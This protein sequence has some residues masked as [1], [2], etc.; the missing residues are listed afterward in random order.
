[1]SGVFLAI[2]CSCWF[3]NLQGGSLTGT[4]VASP[5]TLS[6]TACKAQ[7]NTAIVEEWTFDSWSSKTRPQSGGFSSNSPH[8]EP[9]RARLSN[10]TSCSY[11]GLALQKVP[12]SAADFEGTLCEM[13]TTLEQGVAEQGAE[14]TWTISQQAQAGRRRSRKSR[15]RADR[16]CRK[17]S[18]GGNNTQLQGESSHDTTCNWSSGEFTGGRSWGASA[19]TCS[20]STST[21]R[22]HDED[23]RASTWIAANDGHASP[24]V[25]TEAS[26][27]G[28]EAQFDRDKAQSWPP[29][30]DGQDTAPDY[31]FVGKDYQAGP[32]L[33]GLCGT[34]RGAIPKTQGVVP[35]H[36]CRACQVP[37]AKDPG[38]RADQSRDFKGLPNPIEY[39]GGSGL[40]SGRDGRCSSSSFSTGGGHASGFARRV[41]G[42]G[43]RHGSSHYTSS[44]G[45]GFF[46]EIGCNFAYQSCQGAPQGEGAKQEGSEDWI[47]S[48]L[49]D[50]LH[51]TQHVPV[52]CVVEHVFAGAWS[53]TQANVELHY[54]KDNLD[55]RSGA[56][57]VNSQQGGDGTP[58]R[59][60][61]FNPQVEFIYL[62]GD[63]GSSLFSV[64]EVLPPGELFHQV[65]YSS[66]DEALD[67]EAVIHADSDSVSMMDGDFV[68]EDEDDAYVILHNFG[69]LLASTQ[70]TIIS[71]LE[72]L[73]VITY[74]VR[75]HSLGR[76]DTWVTTATLPH[77]RQAV[78]NLWE[79]AIPQFAACF[80]FAVT[81]QP[82]REL[83]VT[84][85]WILVVEIDPGAS[86]P[87]HHCPILSMT[88]SRATGLIGNPHP[89]LVPKN[90][91]S[92]QLVP[93][94]L[95]SQYCLP[96][97]MRTCHLEIAGEVKSPYEDFVV[98]PGSLSKLLFGEPPPGVCRARQWFPDI[99]EVALD[100][101]A[102]SGQGL[103][104][105]Q[106]VL[107]AADIPTR[108]IDVDG[109]VATDP[110]ALRRRLPP[111]VRKGR[112]CWVPLG[113]LHPSI[114][115]RPGQLH[116]VVGS[117]LRGPSRP[118]LIFICR[119]TAAYQEFWSNAV[120]WIDY[121]TT[122][123]ELIVQLFPDEDPLFR[124]NVV[125]SSNH[126]VL[127]TL[128]QH[129]SGSVIIAYVGRSMSSGG[130]IETA[131]AESIN[132][133][134]RS[135]SLRAVR[136]DAGDSNE[137][138][139]V[140]QLHRTLH[141]NVAAAGSSFQRRSKFLLAQGGRKHVLVSWAT[142][143]V[144]LWEHSRR[145]CSTL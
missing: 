94:H 57:M 25:G 85:A 82:L 71:D 14:G 80:A 119:S 84:K 107:H 2:V 135:M 144:A 114:G 123:E 53:W 103:T 112:L 6:E 129:H 49:V 118:L 12:D 72:P 98:R 145:R 127:G 77:L 110:D 15:G 141:Q 109:T 116:F 89:R 130:L 22:G 117:P 31:S 30:Q 133:M 26:R 120:H 131:G 59:R 21:S 134:Q 24:R 44:C 10:R 9:P 8:V 42:Y 37:H 51:F 20:S 23:P 35:S 19:R 104:H 46:Q 41:R 95:Y 142:P 18:V 33:A 100:M 132:L 40:G 68:E 115:I 39:C 99:E 62:D 75:G 32:G 113:M 143:R 13:W 64:D 93:V 66:D 29:Q 61:R 139:I 92:Q 137:V 11:N 140:L 27:L 70:G 50:E 34:G 45:A 7:A 5:Q 126:A 76:R 136:A 65:D 38:A 47:G 3:V 122:P 124:S 111:D 74:G 4:L 101:V 97:G 96:T 60:V 128:E 1:M 69:V 86:T 91:N 138:H 67:D 52:N 87:A 106:F 83:Q 58:P 81:P 78:W 63:N 28:R 105:F 125:L 108:T 36:P 73:R 54:P 43:G 88:Y 90:T 102:Q 48:T 16:I 56:A 17:D 121:G 55:L 79:D